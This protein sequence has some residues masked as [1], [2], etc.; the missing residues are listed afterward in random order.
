MTR[1]LLAFCQKALQNLLVTPD[2]KLRMNPFQNLLVRI[3]D[4]TDAH[5]PTQHRD[6]A[7]I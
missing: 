4:P 7:T 2:P 1:P 6:E 3:H 5:R